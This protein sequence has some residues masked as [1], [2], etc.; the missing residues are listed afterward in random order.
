NIEHRT[1]NIEHRTSN[2]E[3]RTSNAER[4]TKERSGCGKASSR[5]E[6]GPFYLSP[7]NDLFPD[8]D[9]QSCLDPLSGRNYKA[10]NHRLE[11]DTRTVRGSLDNDSLEII[12]AS[13]LKLW[14]NADTVP[15][16]KR[17]DGIGRHGS[18]HIGEIY[19][20]WQ[21]CW[22]GLNCSD[23]TSVGHEREGVL[24]PFCSLSDS[25]H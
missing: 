5:G 10:G 11:Q 8:P 17:S 9:E 1:S 25:I 15:G 23:L 24:R 4:R 20:S 7:C 2:A 22:K 12:V 3:R 16:N 14:E 19:C 18:V 13:I 6:S 21:G